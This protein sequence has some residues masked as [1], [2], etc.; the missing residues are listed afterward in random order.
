MLVAAVIIF[1]IGFAMIII[2]GLKFLAIK[3]VST[4]CKAK[5]VNIKYRDEEY[6]YINAT[7]KYNN[8]DIDCELHMK[9][10]KETEEDLKDKEFNVY[11]NEKGNIVRQVE[12]TKYKTIIGAVMVGSA[13]AICLLVF[14]IEIAKGW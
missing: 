9:D 13:L 8:K 2:Y 6:I 7:F 11:Y 10:N 12:S 14:L 4:K 3:S 1:T 5:F